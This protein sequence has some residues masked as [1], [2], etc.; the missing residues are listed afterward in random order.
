MSRLVGIAALLKLDHVVTLDMDSLHFFSLKLV[1]RRERWD[2]W[3]NGHLEDK[4]IVWSISSL[5]CS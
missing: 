3:K 2:G 1:G 4:K 5:R